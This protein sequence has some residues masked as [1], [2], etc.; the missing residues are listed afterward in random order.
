EH[1]AATTVDAAWHCSESAPKR[2]RQQDPV[3]EAD[4]AAMSIAR[5]LGEIDPWLAAAASEYKEGKGWGRH[6]FARLEDHCREDF[7]R[8]GRWLRDLAALGRAFKK[9]G[10]LLSAFTG[11]DGGAPL[12]RVRAALIA[13][14]AT[15]RDVQEWIALA[16]RCRLDELREHVRR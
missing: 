13:R 15:E 1:T 5:A 14:V 10:R 12:G 3:L 16:R 11:S 6:G 4:L 7:H 8:S 9:D 2:R